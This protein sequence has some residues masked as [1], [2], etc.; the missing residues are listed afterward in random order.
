MK[1][2]EIMFKLFDTSETGITYNDQTGRFPYRSSQGNEYIMLAY[3]YDTNII[4]LQP[5]KNRQ[6]ATLTTAWNIIH[7]RLVIA[8][9]T[10]KAYI[11]DN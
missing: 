5:V 8:G 11:M 6:A 4:L 3:H 10:P 1:T 2:N 9:V 7:N